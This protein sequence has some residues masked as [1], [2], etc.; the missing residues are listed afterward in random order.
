MIKDKFTRD[1]FEADFP[2]FNPLHD[3]NDIE[4]NIWEAPLPFIELECGLDHADTYKLLVDQSDQ[5]LIEMPGEQIRLA[6]KKSNGDLWFY[7][8]HMEGWRQLPIFGEM[9]TIKKIICSDND[10]N[11]HK[12]F[13]EKLWKTNIR[14][15]KKLLNQ[16]EKLGCAVKRMVVDTLDINGWVRPHQDSNRGKP[17]LYAWI[18]L[19]DFDPCL[20]I[21]PHG[22]LKHKLGNI[23]LLANTKFP[24][25]VI[26]KMPFRRYVAIIK[27]DEKNC[28]TFFKKFVI[29]S[30]KKQWY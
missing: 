23:Y 6:E 29:D 10:I 4:K 19:H 1:F 26:N 21:W 13:K 17:L 20:K 30:A 12:D 9:Y 16:L 28:S 7:S 18:P 25:S 15:G 11:L 8:S 27:I 5:H 22:L 24:H 14:F 3:W 2:G